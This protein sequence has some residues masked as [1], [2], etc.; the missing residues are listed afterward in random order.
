MVGADIFYLD[1]RDIENTLSIAIDLA[2]GRLK[3][4]SVPWLLNIYFVGRTLFI[5]QY[6]N[7]IR[8]SM[9]FCMATEC[10]GFFSGGRRVLLS[11]KS[12]KSLEYLMKISDIKH[13]P[14]WLLP[15]GWIKQ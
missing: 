7:D 1:N 2:E 14:K 5:D 15:R 13:E 10:V 9:T 8:D 12:C 11:I 4:S 6:C 3:K